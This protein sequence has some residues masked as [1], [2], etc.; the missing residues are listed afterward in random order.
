MAQ[1]DNPLL[2]AIQAVEAPSPED[3]ARFQ[4]FRPTPFGQELLGPEFR[5]PA[6]FDPFGGLPQADPEGIQT[7]LTALLT[8]GTAGALGTMRAGT[9][10][11]TTG[12]FFGGGR[13]RPL[14]HGANTPQDA[15][16]ILDV[17][18][19]EG[20]SSELNLPG[21]SVTED[22]AIAAMFTGQADDEFFTARNFDQLLAVELGLDPSQIANLDP[23]SYLLGR[24]HGAIATRK[25]NEFFSEAETFLVRSDP[26]ELSRMRKTGAPGTAVTSVERAP[27][28]PEARARPLTAAEKERISKDLK[29]ARD[30]FVF[31][32]ENFV[33]LTPPEAFKRLGDASQ[34]VRNLSGLRGTRGRRMQELAR[35]LQSDNPNSATSVMR[36][37]GDAVG[38]EELGRKA[39]RLRATAADLI[40]TN[41]VIDNKRA[42][43]DQL[44]F[45]GDT[46]G[47]QEALAGINDDSRKMARLRDKLERDL[48]ALAGHTLKPTRPVTLRRPFRSPQDRAEEIFGIDEPTPVPKVIKGKIK[49]KAGKLDAPVISFQGSTFEFKSFNAAKGFFIDEVTGTLSPGPAKHVELANAVFDAATTKQLQEAVKAY[50]KFIK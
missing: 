48:N 44:R 24:T 46:K 37:L 4:S 8:G 38:D 47:A 36:R 35:T 19:R 30:P 12:A 41:R 32:L 15:D 17:G 7:V 39:V 45:R 25:P 23:E 16:S 6:P 5:T 1:F 2:R 13:K 33:N 50:E 31:E 18:F 20:K 34:S 28:V 9:G 42:A 29:A 11:A 49:A 3:V 26:F 10:A 14:F 21:T 40:N 22:P 43:A 27:P